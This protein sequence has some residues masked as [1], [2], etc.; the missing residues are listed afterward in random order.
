MVGIRNSQLSEKL[1]LDPDL[2]LDK[3]INAARQN[4]AVKGQQTVIRSQEYEERIFAVVKDKEVTGKQCV[5]DAATCVSKENIYAL[6]GQHLATVV[7]N[8]VIF[9][10][11]AEQR[12]NQ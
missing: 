9:N 7:D 6:P 5:L 4:E 12:T 10:Q 1:W 8:R 11:C 3:V 2:T